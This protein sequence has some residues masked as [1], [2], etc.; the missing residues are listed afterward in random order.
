MATFN[1]ATLRAL[2]DA[3]EVAIRTGKHPDTAVV[4]WIVVE[5]DTVFVRSVRGA[6]GRWF[7]DLAGGGDALLE[8]GALQVP[9]RAAPATDAASVARA[10]V[11]Y[12]GK[13]SDS[14]YAQPM[15]R[16]EVLATTLRLD[17]R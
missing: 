16:A 8:C 2:R 17:P 9:V 7:R 10:S 14:P 6:K 13:Y 4:I 12:L 3:R 11:A 5:G 15:V 1:E